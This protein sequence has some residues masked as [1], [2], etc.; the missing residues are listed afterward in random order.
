MR[1]VRSKERE[2]MNGDQALTSLFEGEM[3][4]ILLPDAEAEL[5]DETEIVVFLRCWKTGD[6]VRDVELRV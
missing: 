4:R 1:S 6:R 2:E 5:K 3:K